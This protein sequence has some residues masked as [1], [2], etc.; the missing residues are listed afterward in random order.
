MWIERSIHYWREGYIE[1]SFYAIWRWH[2]AFDSWRSEDV[3]R[4]PGARN[5]SAAS[6][7]SKR[8]RGSSSSSISRG[9]GRA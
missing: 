1:R 8:A 7:R 3:M 4:K 9:L 6:G 5:G 2:R